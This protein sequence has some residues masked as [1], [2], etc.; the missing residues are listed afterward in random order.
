MREQRK[1]WAWGWQPVCRRGLQSSER[2][3]TSP[4]R[5]LWPKKFGSRISE[6]P[7]SLQT[8]IWLGIV[9]QRVD[10]PMSNATTS[11]AIARRATVKYTAILKRV[12]VL[13]VESSACTRVACCQRSQLSLN[14]ILTAAAGFIYSKVSQ[15]HQ[16]V[17]L[18]STTY[19]RHR[20][21]AFGDNG[22]FCD[23]CRQRGGSN[24]MEGVCEGEG[25]VLDNGQSLPRFHQ[26]QLRYRRLT[27]LYLP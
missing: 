22:L 21:D 10:W 27:L 6:Y 19:Q 3:T 18:L 8:F 9:T 24:Q 5:L 17:S 25:G 7:T 15:P 16:P 14:G 1:A 12:W 20:D 13:K 23:D 2:G 11:H 4:S 26:V